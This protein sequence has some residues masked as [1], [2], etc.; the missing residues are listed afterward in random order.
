MTVPRPSDEL[1][2]QALEVIADMLE[3]GEAADGWALG[4]LRAATMFPELMGAKE[5]RIAL[6]IEK[7]GNF[8][9]ERQ[10]EMG[11]PRPRAKLA[12]TDVWAADDIRAYAARRAKERSD[13]DKQG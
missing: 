3:H 4:V 9:T 11:V 13:G 8:G 7:S 2:E 5:A 10:R 1:I 12:A 6:S